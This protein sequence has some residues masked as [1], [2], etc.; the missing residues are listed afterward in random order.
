V[1]GRVFVN[2]IGMAN[3][4][5]TATGD[6]GAVTATERTLTGAN[7]YYSFFL[8][9]GRYTVTAITASGSASRVVV[10]PPG[11]QTV[12]NVDFNL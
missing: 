4:Q 12:D 1:R 6:S 2:R 7:G 3:I 8:G 10:V 9:Q 11:G 5:V